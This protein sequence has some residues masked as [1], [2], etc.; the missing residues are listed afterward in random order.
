MK[1]P[2]SRPR[3]A[4]PRSSSKKKKTGKRT[5]AKPPKSS[6]TAGCKPRLPGTRQEQD[7]KLDPPRRRVEDLDVVE[8]AGEERSS[9]KCP[10]EA[11]T[12]LAAAAALVAAIRLQL[13]LRLRSRKIRLPDGSMMSRPPPT[14]VHLPSRAVVHAA[15]VAVADG[16]EV[17]VENKA[18]LARPT[19]LNHRL[20]LP[21]TSRP[22]PPR[23]RPSTLRHRA[24]TRLLLPLS[25]D[26][27]KD[28]CIRKRAQLLYHQGNHT[29]M[30]L[31]LT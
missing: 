19:A 14:R 5:S 6:M 4:L 13:R 20:L 16:V 11:K 1:E 29:H 12:K 23:P 18:S 10:L 17:V 25:L 31:H 8:D 26:A 24:S 3:E 28:D 27:P 15:E 30:D 22:S 21:P 2:K 7:S 9:A